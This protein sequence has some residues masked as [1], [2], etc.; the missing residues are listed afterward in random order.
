MF[1]SSS[2]YHIC[3]ISGLFR[4]TLVMEHGPRKNHHRP[5]LCYS[6]YLQIIKASVCNDDRQ[7]HYSHRA[8]FTMKDAV[9]Q[10]VVH[11]LLTGLTPVWLS[12]VE[13]TLRQLHKSTHKC[14]PANR[15]TNGL[16]DEQENIW[17]GSEVL[18]L[19]DL[20]WHFPVELFAHNHDKVKWGSLVSNRSETPWYFLPSMC[21]THSNNPH[22]KYW[23]WNLCSHQTIPAW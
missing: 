20:E 18:S 9:G 15:Q 17:S 11:S 16:A 1:H 3:W 4:S 21:H 22:I 19:H 13:L 7:P 14:N 6:L 12:G 5:D 23:N 10:W 8:A 2:R